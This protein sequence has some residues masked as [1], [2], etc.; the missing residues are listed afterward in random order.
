MLGVPCS[1]GNTT[2]FLSWLAAEL[3]DLVEEGYSLLG[4]LN[5]SD[6]L[7]FLADLDLQQ[8]RLVPRVNRFVQRMADGG[9]GA[10]ADFLDVLLSLSDS[11]MIAVLWVRISRHFYFKYF[12][13]HLA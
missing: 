12:L 2:T 10:A 1:A 13:C 5:W 9:G 4:L 8:I 3:Y 7:P 6:H 11:D